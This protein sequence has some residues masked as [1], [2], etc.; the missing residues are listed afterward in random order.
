MDQSTKRF[1]S[2]CSTFT[3]RMQE[4]L[5]MTRNLKIGLTLTIFISVRFGNAFAE[6]Q[7]IFNESILNVGKTSN[8]THELSCSDNATFDEIKNTLANRALPFVRIFCWC[9]RVVLTLQKI[10]LLLLLYIS[11]LIPSQ[12]C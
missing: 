4:L 6:A 12:I 2:H 10:L 8:M 5:S 3:R 9:K 1:K 7:L 11:L